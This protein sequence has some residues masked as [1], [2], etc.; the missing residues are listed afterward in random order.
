MNEL[1][2][3][4]N[5]PAI[6]ER[7]WSFLETIG[8]SRKETIMANLLAYYFDPGKEHGLDDTFIK[9]LLQTVPFYLS[10]KK[11]IKIDNNEKERDKHQ[12]KL[13]QL[14]KFTNENY[15]FNWANIIVEDSTDKNKRIDIVIETEDLVIAI[16]FKINHN[17]NNPLENYFN[18]IEGIDKNGK[19]IVNAKNVGK[20]KYYVVLTP[21][22]KYPEGKARNN[23]EFVQITLAGFIENVKKIVNDNDYYKG[24]EN[25]HQFFIYQDLINTIENRGKEITMINTYFKGF[26]I[27]SEKKYGKKEKELSYEKL[28]DTYNNLNII[29]KYIENQINKLMIHLNKNEKFSFSIINA[30]KN[31]LDSA[32]GTKVENGNEIKIR[33]SLKGWSIELYGKDDKNKYGELKVEYIEKDKYET[34]N[35]ISCDIIE[36]KLM[37]YYQWQ[38]KSTS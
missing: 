14:K 38:T 21:V 2:L 25:S 5:L 30:T 16:E 6:E 17:L 33:L 23:K 31:R 32:I 15:S 27:D 7:E 29:K 35:N 34:A 8:A 20:Q 24:K 18:H 26:E 4:K 28:E 19:R 1:E 9:A 13:I 10:K 3:L 12:E 37:E 22:W 11:K 36:K